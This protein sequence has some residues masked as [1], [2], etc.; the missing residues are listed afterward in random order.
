MVRFALN[1]SLRVSPIQEPVQRQQESS[2][3]RAERE[4]HLGTES[5]GEVGQRFGGQEGAESPA[6][7]AIRERM[8]LSIGSLSSRLRL[9][10]ARLSDWASGPHR[11]EIQ[12]SSLKSYNRRCRWNRRVIFFNGRIP[13]PE[14]SKKFNE[15]E[16]EWLNRRRR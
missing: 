12:S 8:S 9:S 13:S 11:R 10:L 7:P 14:E 16:R 2:R 1:L 3:E 5:P 15:W 4:T 6:K